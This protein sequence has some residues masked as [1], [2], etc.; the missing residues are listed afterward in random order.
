MR[1]GVVLTLAVAATLVGGCV[2][3]YMSVVGYPNPDLPILPQQR[4]VTISIGSTIG[5]DLLEKNLLAVVRNELETRG[6]VYDE[7]N[8]DLVVGVVGYI[9]PFEYYVAPSTVYWPMP[10]HQT[11]T[12][13]GSAYGGGVSV[14]GRSTT[15]TRGQQWVPITRPG[16]VETAYYRRID[17]LVG[18]VVEG[19]DSAK[20]ELAW[21]G[22]VES[23][24]RT[25]DLLTVAPILVNELFTEFPKRS[26]RAPERRR[27]I[28]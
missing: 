12:S 15:R 21:T 5:G 27:I 16:G 20:V 11:S 23:S 3:M 4:F 17:V 9:G 28:Q 19:V 8:P 22:H 24:G 2:P 25:S 14:Y 1:C 6:F 18:E 7:Q 10:T 13:S 26:G